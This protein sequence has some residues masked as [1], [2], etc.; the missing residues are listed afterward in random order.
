MRKW[1]NVSIFAL[2][3]LSLS[4]VGFA[5]DEP[6]KRAT[7]SVVIG[8]VQ[9][10]SAAGG[11]NSKDVKETIQMGLKKQLEKKSKGNYSVSISNPTADAG[12]KEKSPE[13]SALPTNRQPTQAEIMKYMKAMQKM[14]S[15]MMSDTRKFSPVIAD[16]YFDFK[17]QTSKSEVDTGSAASII[18]DFAGV[19][20]SV[21]DISTKS[22]NVYLICSMRN[23]ASGDLIDRYTAKVSS[24]KFRNIAGVSSYYYGDDG[25][26]RERLFSQAVKKCAK[27]MNKKLK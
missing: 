19:D 11:S 22:T 1:T 20:T 3:L 21:G 27:W 17:L 12:D 18:G 15:E 9:V 25:I 26:E 6:V 13:M 5:K 23:P 14:Q 16:A 2:V 10:G 4:V 8:D 7:K 24:V